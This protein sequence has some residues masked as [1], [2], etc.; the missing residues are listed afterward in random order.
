M[1]QTFAD[2]TK[3]KHEKMPE[4]DQVHH[5]VEDFTTFWDGEFT[6]IG[7]LRRF[8]DHVLNLD[9]RRMSAEVNTQAQTAPV[10]RPLVSW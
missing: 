3:N 6:H 7:P 8:V 2:M 1:N 10:W 4:A 5:I 9:L